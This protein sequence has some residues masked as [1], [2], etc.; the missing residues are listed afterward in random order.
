MS[1]SI[2]TKIEEFADVNK[3]IENYKI[4]NNDLIFTND[5]IYKNY[6]KNTKAKV[7]L[8]NDY[9]NGEPS[10][11]LVERLYADIKDF[12]YNRVIAIGGGAILDVGKILALEDISPVDNLFNGTIEVKKGCEMIAVPTTCGTGSEVTNISILALIKKNTKLGLANVA[13]YPDK[14]VLIPQLLEGLP[15]GVFATSSID[16]LIHAC[17]SF[18][19]PNATSYSKIF[20]REAIKIILK[21]Y[22][23][24]ALCKDNVKRNLRDLL[25]A[26]NYA[27]IAFSNA[28]CALVHAMSY[29]L[30]AKYH[31][32]HGESNYVLFMAVYKKY[33]SI[34]SDGAIDELFSFIAEVLGCKKEDA[35]KELEALLE[36][37]LPL[38]Q[39]SKYGAV[40]EDIE[41]FV[42]IVV[43]KQGRLTKNNFVNVSEKQIKEI[44]ESV[45]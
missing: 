40:W 20:S 24:I 28:G 9:G 34:K 39:M 5:V 37:I 43:T 17:E 16:A 30:G 31:V 14:A 32:P 38:K 13:L 6:L 33:L 8:Y 36:N 27:G 22:K 41:E 15:Y 35:I 23:D 2:N 18:T 21:A 19:S 26:S 44:Y 12:N 45:F 25:V 4:N 3:F 42:K 11:E 7:F 10:D 29:P 1:F